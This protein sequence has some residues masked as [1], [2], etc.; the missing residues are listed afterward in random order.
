VATRSLDVLATP[1]ADGVVVRTL[2]PGTT[3]SVLL[4]D[5]G[6]DLIAKDGVQLGYV[7]ANG[8]ALLQ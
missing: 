6:W 5:N 2:A 3:V 1:S 4:T 8:L 7:L